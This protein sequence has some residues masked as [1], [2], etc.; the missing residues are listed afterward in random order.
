MITEIVECLS[1]AGADVNSQSEWREGH[2][3]LHLAAEKGSVRLVECLVG[4]G[5]DIHARDLSGK[6]PLHK[7]VL[8][9]AE[10]VEYLLSLDAGMCN[11]QDRQGDT[12]L[13]LAS[14]NGSEATVAC[15]LDVG[16]DVHALGKYGMTPLDWA[17]TK[18]PPHTEEDRRETACKLAL[19]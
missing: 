4:I 3:P 18:L 9:S 5:A 7:S 11:A 14:R 16:A 1:C 6:L 10:V 2:T 8:N 12:P 15:L 13:H 17:T 19:L